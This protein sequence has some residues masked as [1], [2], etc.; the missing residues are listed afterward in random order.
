VSGRDRAHEEFVA[1]GPLPEGANLPDAEAKLLAALEREI[2]VSLATTSTA[3]P[4][5]P[6]RMRPLLAFAA[7]V[8]AAAGLAWSLGSMKGDEEVLRGAADVD[9]WAAQATSSRLDA[10]RMRLSWPAA[11]GATR[12]AVTFLSG[13][14]RELARVEDLSGTELVLDGG[15]L[16]V[17]L[18]SG[19]SVLWRV[20]AYSGRD[21]LAQSPAAPLQLP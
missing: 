20:A 1:P 9:G 19:E 10:R 17:G 12:Y 18:A 13:D 14:L 16:P 5:R 2:G 8:L 11:P 3:R 21:P 6:S 4:G 15:A 7:V